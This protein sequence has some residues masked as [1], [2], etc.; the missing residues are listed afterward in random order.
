M[1]DENKVK[2]RQ[3]E[4]DNSRESKLRMEQMIRT[5]SDEEHIRSCCTKGIIGHTE[6]EVKE[7]M[8]D[9]R[10][11]KGPPPRKVLGMYID[12]RSK[13]YKK[14]RRKK[15]KMWK[16]ASSMNEFFELQRKEKCCEEGKA[17]FEEFNYSLKEKETELITRNAK[18]EDNSEPRERRSK[19]EGYESE[20]QTINHQSNVCMT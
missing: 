2:C 9:I 8:N 4:A 16:Y 12:K 10:I 19:L 1:R 18:R 11:G 6:N 14:R 3:K 15:N 17:Q 7:V 20:A 5:W 13:N